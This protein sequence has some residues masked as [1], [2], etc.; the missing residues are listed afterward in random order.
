MTASETIADWA[1]GL[2]LE[3]VPDRAVSAAHIHLLDGI[4][5]A[6]AAARRDEVPFALAVARRFSAPPEATVIGSGDR[7]PAPAAALANGSLV[8]ALD[9]DDTHQGA[10]VHATAAVLP[11]AFAVGEEVSA[12]GA[13]V[14]AACIAGYEVV[15]RLGAAVTHGF[16]ARGFHATSVCGVFAAAL[17]AS[18]LMQLGPAETVNA[19]GLAG[20]QASGSLEF[21]NT[22]SSTKQLHP[23]FS[24]MAGVM[25]A[26]L[27][28]DGADGPASI[29]EGEHGLYRSFAGQEVNPEALTD[30]L[31]TRWET[32]RITVKPYP[33]CQ[34]SHASLDALAKVLPEIPEASR[35]ERVEFAVPPESIPIVCEP[36]ETKLRPRTPYEGKFSLQYCAAAMLVDRGISLE[37]FDPPGL[38]RPE[39]LEV[40]SRVV[41]RALEFD[42]APADA[43]G[44][45]EVTLEGGRTLLGEVPRSRGGP[46]APLSDDELRAKFTANAAGAQ[47]AEKLG[48]MLLRLEELPALS[49]VVAATAVG[50]PAMT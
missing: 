48:T 50:A 19:L 7:L 28:A 39:L 13:D 44:I 15:I 40:A 20:S 23:G 46:D 37:T 30:G 29:L 18:R 26:R 34:L 33:V 36:V 5:C 25:A 2:R 17:A 47:E 14:L 45:V 42:G 32:E 11:A 4:G 31:G 24:G 35:V 6:I 22:A 38:Q 12:R 21:L 8:H 49:P 10:L 3:D 16:H 9:F 1:L 43:P 27:A 41:H